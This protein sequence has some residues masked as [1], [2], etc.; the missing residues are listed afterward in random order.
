LAKL[1][2]YSILIALSL[3]SIFCSSVLFAGPGVVRA[4]WVTASGWDPHGAYVDDVVYAVYPSED[5]AQAILALR[6]GEIDA[7]DERIPYTQLKDLIND[8]DITVNISLGSIYRQLTLNSERFPTNI[9]GYRR[10]LAFGMDKYKVMEEAIGGVG[11]PLDSYIPTVATEWE[12]ESSLTTHFYDKDI[13]SAN[14]S[15]EAA[16]FKDLDGDGWREYDVNGND[17][18]DAGTDL[19]TVDFAIEMGATAGYDPAIVACE[20][21][22]EGMAEMGLMATVIEKDFSALI[23]DAINFGDFYVICFSWSIGVVNPPDLFFD[24]FRTGQFYAD[25]LYRFSNTTHIDP[26]I[27]TMMAATTLTEAKAAAIVVTELL[28]YEQ[29]MIVCYNDAYINAWRNDKFDGFFTYT[30]RGQT[31]SNNYICTH[32]KLKPEFGGPFGGEFRFAMS[33]DLETTNPM[34][35][36]EGYTVRLQGFIWEGLWKTD[37][38]DWNP[39]PSLAYDWDIEQTTASGDIQDG[40]KFTFYLYENATWHDG[41]AVM[42]DDVVYSI[43][44]ITPESPEYGFLVANTYKVEA[45]DDYTVELY[46]N[47]SGYFEWGRSTGITIFPKHVWTGIANFTAPL[48]DADIIGSGPYKWVENVAGEYTALARHEDWHFG[49]EHT[50]TTVTPPPP[51]MTL[52]LLAGVGV[53]VIV[54][55]VIAGVYYFRIRK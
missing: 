18:W 39:I 22:A 48:A 53:A 28:A 50:P 25:Y 24:L 47:A 5:I 21:T 16:G 11:E 12:V 2:K 37:P 32:V 52:L 29:P 27:D 8:P 40:Q 45:P 1:K 41:E 14:A 4:G 30:G 19:D 9:T 42:S 23:S 20:V 17:V 36:S 6:T 38:W 55:I 15:L 46:T 13:V 26:A 7:Y 31:G 34:V 33:E 54:I 51:D 44:T 49:V 43:E 10:A 35:A 3:V